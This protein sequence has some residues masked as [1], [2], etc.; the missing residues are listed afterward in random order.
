[1]EADGSSPRGVRYEE[2]TPALTKAV[3]E[4]DARLLALEAASNTPNVGGATITTDS[5]KSS[6]ASFGVFVSDAFTHIKN[7]TV[8]SLTVGSSSNPTG[9]TLFDEN[10]K[11]PYCLTIA[12]GSPKSTSGTCKTYLDNANQYIAPVDPP[13]IN[14]ATDTPAIINNNNAT[15]TPPIIIDNNVATDT[16]PVLPNILDNNVA[17]D[18]PQ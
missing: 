1:M 16:P 3:Q 5:L 11:Q 17:T 18:T 9:V 2:I 6:L 10:T 4:I 14:N 15:D 8:D 12:D 7:L 13:I